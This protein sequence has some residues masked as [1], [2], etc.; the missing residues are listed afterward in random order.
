MAE[1]DT[2]AIVMKW[3]AAANAQDAEQLAAL[4]DVSIE[5]VGPRGSGHGHAL[6]R[7]WLA[8]A[9]L[10]LET[11]RMFTR[12]DEVVVEQRGVWRSAET[13]A[14]TGDRLVASYFRVHDQAIT[15]FERF[16]ALEDAL[17]A[18]HLTVADEAR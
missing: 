12:G 18:A 16:D 14:I 3:L 15:R 8:R 9:G 1:S 11:H 4:S 2:I 6:L 5:I 17:A 13:G 10:T 7:E